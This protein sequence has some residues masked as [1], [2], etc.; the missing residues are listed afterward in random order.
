[1]K[2]Q[3]V[4]LELLLSKKVVDSTGKSAGRIHEIHAEKQGSEWLVK[5]YVIGIAG[6]L[7]RLSILNVGLEILQRLG[8][9]QT[10]GGYIVPWDKL[11]LTDLEKPRLNC[12]LDE[13][14]K[15]DKFN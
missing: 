7:E 9:R 2:S 10:Q 12:T 14:R 6:L 13:L 11:D 15:F 1:M 5:E 3:E 4:H 8:A